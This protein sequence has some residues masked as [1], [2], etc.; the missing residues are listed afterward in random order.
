MSRLQ[1]AIGFEN[2]VTAGLALIG[3]YLVREGFRLGLGDIS[4]PEA[5]AFLFLSGV[6]LTGLSIAR[7]VVGRRSSADDDAAEEAPTPGGTTKVIAFIVA[8][9]VYTA[10]LDW[11]GF[12]VATALLAA[13]IMKI[14]YRPGW[15]AVCTVSI[16]SALLVYLLFDVL[17]GV[18]LPAGTVL[19]G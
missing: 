12:I 16:A 13:A 3:L 14:S 4:V 17:L 1:Q 18:S 2:A 15:I 19:A 11:L 5:G 8:L 6:A 9:A 10:V 7:L